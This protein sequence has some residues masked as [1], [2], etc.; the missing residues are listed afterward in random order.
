VPCLSTQTEANASEFEGITFTLAPAISRQ[1]KL[2]MIQKR[3]LRKNVI[4][5]F[6][7]WVNGDDPEKSAWDPSECIR[8]LRSP[9]PA[10]ALKEAERDALLVVLG[11]AHWTRPALCGTVKGER[12]LLSLCALKNILADVSLQKKRVRECAC[13][14]GKWFLAERQNQRYYGDHRKVAWQHG[15]TAEQKK[16]RRAQNQQA[17]RRFYDR[18]LKADPAK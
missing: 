10:A 15:M 3:L 14:C 12:S 18:E 17:Q 7:E 11:I 9:E 8:V 13:G 4:A 1:I 2:G 5:G 16:R 6:L